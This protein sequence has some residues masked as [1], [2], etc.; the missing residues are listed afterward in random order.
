MGESSFRRHKELELMA[1]A[2]S[3]PLAAA[4]G[5]EVEENQEG[6]W[7]LKSPRMRELLGSEKERMDWKSGV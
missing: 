6:W 2:N 5:S 4:V 3:S 1:S 7:E